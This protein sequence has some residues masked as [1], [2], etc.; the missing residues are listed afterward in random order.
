MSETTSGAYCQHL[1]AIRGATCICDTVFII[2]IVIFI[3]TKIGAVIK[4]AY[5][6]TFFASAANSQQA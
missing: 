6:D 1:A 5:Y 3:A 2:I 4:F